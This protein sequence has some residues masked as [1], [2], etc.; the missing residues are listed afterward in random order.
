MK[1]TTLDRFF[2]LGGFALALLLAALGVVL[3]SNAN[4]ANDYVHNQLSA[5]QITFTPKAGLAPAEQKTACL[6]ANAGEALTTGKQAEC[7][8]NEYIAVHLKEVN[9]G[10]TYAQTSGAARA[11]RTEATTAADEGAKNADALDAQATELEGKVQTLFRGETLRGLLLTSYGF[12]EF[13]RKADQA[14]TV[15]FLAAA[16]LLLASIAG[17]VHALRTPKSEVVE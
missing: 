1:R 14:A 11:A 12:S 2:A 5:Q 17:A 4:F 15:A 3:T 7:Y 9:G 6:R 16:V 10:K 8:A 13:G